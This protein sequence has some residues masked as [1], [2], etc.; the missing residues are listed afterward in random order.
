MSQDWLI[1]K[2]GPPQRVHWKGQPADSAACNVKTAAYHNTLEQP[3]VDVIFNPKLFQAV[4]DVD[5][6]SALPDTT[7][8][9][10]I[11]MAICQIPSNWKMA[12]D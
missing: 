11:P 6:S 1:S 7:T 9:L 10:A 2:L 8:R 4:H 12:F 5:F 3:E